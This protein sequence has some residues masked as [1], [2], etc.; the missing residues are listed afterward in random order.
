MGKSQ[1]KSATI[2]LRLKPSTKRL[3]EKRAKQ[4]GRSVSNYI[5]RL[6]EADKREATEPGD[7][8]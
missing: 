4:Q 5:E 7:S 2:T 3:A 6:I 1:T 8:D